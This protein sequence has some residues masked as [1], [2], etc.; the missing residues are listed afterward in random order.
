ME[1]AVSTVFF[2]DSKNS[3][4]RGVIF[5]KTK[6]S[7]ISVNCSPTDFSGGYRQS[8]QVKQDFRGVRSRC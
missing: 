1:K 6:N 7:K 3:D 5:E 4:L 2:V 8:S